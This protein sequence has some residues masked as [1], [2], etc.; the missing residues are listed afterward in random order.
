MQKWEHWHV[1]IRYRSGDSHDDIQ[2]ALDEHE[3][4]GWE[5]VSATID[6]LRKDCHLFFKRRVR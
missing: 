3:T 1:I 2:T 6:S 4:E 5:L